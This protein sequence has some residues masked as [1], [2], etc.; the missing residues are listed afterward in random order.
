MSHEKN[1]PH[2]WIVTWHFNH[3]KKYITWNHL[4]ICQVFMTCAKKSITLN[5]TLYIWMKCNMIIFHTHW[6]FYN[7]SLLLKTSDLDNAAVACAILETSAFA[8]TGNSGCCWT[9]KKKKLGEETTRLVLNIQKEIKH[10]RSTIYWSR[11]QTDQ[12]SR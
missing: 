9:G 12:N 8:K 5:I 7:Q 1:A 10:K 11:S 3:R 4:I 2:S 6:Q